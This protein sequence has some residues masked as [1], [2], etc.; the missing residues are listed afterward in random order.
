[1]FPL[2]EEGDIESEPAL[3]GSWRNEDD[4]ISLEIAA[5]EWGSYAVTW[6]QASTTY[7]GRM[8]L[9]RVAG[10]L[11][12]DVTA[13]PGEDRGP[14]LVVVH[15]WCRVQLDG[16]RLTIQPLDH[17]WLSG[18]TG[19]QVAPVARADERGDLLLTG[20]TASLRR[21]LARHARRTGVLDAPIT[22]QRVCGPAGPQPC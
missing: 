8:Y 22:F 5:A 2:Y 13:P 9:T 15:W 10:D 6:R 11:F 17:D 1:L 16:D 14:F 19:R 12:A 18:P 20:G 21:W 3:V 7:P 4:R